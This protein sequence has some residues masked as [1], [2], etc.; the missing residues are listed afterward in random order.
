MP[1]RTGPSRPGRSRTGRS[2]TARSRTAPARSPEPVRT[3]PVRSRSLRAPATRARPLRTAAPRLPARRLHP[4]LHGPGPSGPG[5]KEGRPKRGRIRRFFRLRT[6][7]VILALIA[8]FCCWAAFSVGQALTA[9]GGGSTSAK[10]AEWARDHYLGPVVTFGEWISYN[11]P[12]AGGKPGFSLAAPGGTTPARDYKKTHG[13]A[14]NIPQQA[15]LPGRPSRCPARAPGGCWRRSRATRPSSAR[16]CGRARC[17]PPTWRASSRW[18]SGWSGSRCGPAPR[19][20]A[21]ATGRPRRGSRR[22]PARACWPRSTA[23]SSWTRRAAASTSTARTR[24]PW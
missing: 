11:P 3:Q 22:A 7:R 14:P 18:T 20:R 9:P 21:R 23:G 16:S 17:T 13:F 1:R 2:R 10:L 15:H 6:V 4:H 19:T 12:K 8:V 5:R 24:A